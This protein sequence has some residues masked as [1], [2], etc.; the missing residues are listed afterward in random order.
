MRCRLIILFISISFTAF[1]QQKPLERDTSFSNYSAYKS[2]LKKY[3]NITLANPPVPAN[4]TSKTNVV[5]CKIGDRELHLN[6]FYPTA[7]SKKPYP[8]VLMIH[9]G[10]W[11]SGDRSQHIPMAQQIAAKGYVTITVE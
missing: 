6:I 5:Y 11:R 7:K 3:P 10:G 1:S 4:I 9:G 2:A 8:A